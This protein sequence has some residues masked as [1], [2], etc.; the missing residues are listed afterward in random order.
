M[1]R[2]APEL[3]PARCSLAQQKVGK[4]GVG[5]EFGIGEGEEALDVAD[6]EE[7][8]TVVI[9]PIFENEREFEGQEIVAAVPLIDGEGGFS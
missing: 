4:L 3:E 9:H 6:G 1:G 2:V 7:D 5:A 8:A